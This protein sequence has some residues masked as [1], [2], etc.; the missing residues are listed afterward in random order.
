LSDIAKV[1]TG[2]LKVDLETFDAAACIQEAV[3]VL[4][5]QLE[6]RKQTLTVRADD[7]PKV[8]ADYKRLV[9]MLTY[10]LTNSIAIPRRRTNSVQAEV[11]DRAV[12]FAVIDNGVGVAASDQPRLFTQFF[13]SEDQAV[14]DHKAG[15]GA[16]PGETTAGLLVARRGR[17]RGGAW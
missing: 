2:R 15:V 11:Q 17:E 12:R 14:R 1:E 3:R 7:L 13:R 8:Y 10:L 16:Q 5:P 4:Q 9:Q 6:A